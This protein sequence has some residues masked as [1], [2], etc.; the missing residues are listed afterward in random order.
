MATAREAA[1]RA[2]VL[3]EALPYIQRFRGAV[4]VVK[5][6]GNAMVDPALATTF[7]EDVVLMALRQDP[8]RFRTEGAM[9][10]WIAANRPESSV[11]LTD[12]AES[13]DQVVASARRIHAA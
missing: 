2:D 12:L 8:S 1:V 7:A 10:R 3:V 5:Y 11:G 4:V 6:G 13:L 9:H